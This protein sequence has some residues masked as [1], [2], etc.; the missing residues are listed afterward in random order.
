MSFYLSS[1]GPRA[2]NAYPKLEVLDLSHN[3]I[4]SVSVESFSGLNSL[5]KLC[6]SYNR[7][8]TLEPRVFTDIPKVRTIDLSKNPLADLPSN[9]FNGCP[10]LSRLELRATQLN[11]DD[12]EDVNM[13]SKLEYLE[14]S[15][16]NFTRLPYMMLS[17]LN[18]LGNLYL[19]QSNVHTIDTNAFVG[20]RSLT[21]LEL[22]GNHIKKVN[23]ETYQVMERLSFFNI[24][25]NDLSC[26]CG[27]SQFKDWLTQTGV[28]LIGEA[29][30]TSDGDKQYD[31]HS[32]DLSMFCSGTGPTSQPPGKCGSYGRIRLSVYETSSSMAEITWTYRSVPEDSPMK[33]HLRIYGVENTETWYD[34]RIGER[35]HKFVNLTHDSQ[36]SLCIFQ[37][38]CLLYTCIDFSTARDPTTGEKKGVECIPL[39]T[40]LG[41]G[42]AAGA[43]LLAVGIASMYLIFKGVCCCG[44]QQEKEHEEEPKSPVRQTQPVIPMQISQSYIPS[45]NMRHKRF[46]SITSDTYDA[47]PLEPLDPTRNDVFLNPGYNKERPR[48]VNDPLPP[49]IRT[50]RN[51]D[52]TIINGIRSYY[53]HPD[54]SSLSQISAAVSPTPRSA[55]VKA[56]EMNGLDPMMSIKDDRPKRMPDRGTWHTINHMPKMTHAESEPYHL[57]SEAKDIVV[58]ITPAIPDKRRMFMAGGPS[59]ENLQKQMDGSTGRVKKFSRPKL[60]D[61]HFHR[62]SSGLARNRSFSQPDLLSARDSRLELGGRDLKSLN[63]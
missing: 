17:K 7:I 43:I 36:Y 3:L 63:V 29:K 2:F 45:N 33:G 18:N 26:D 8:S 38:D 28:R 32:D 59:F 57:Y 47:I 13:L 50:S 6:I 62:G 40:S 51:D 31:I 48:N 14:I 24:A 19:S 53:L 25:G 16:N 56:Q 55:E 39:E 12:F 44:N 5:L 58:D 11:Q 22:S 61:K 9:I 52:C 10:W 37:L 20:L 46:Q 60:T 21:T 4:S 41:L 1:A 35:R 15:E 34:L 49:I 23:R 54:D 30:C 27:T 42:V